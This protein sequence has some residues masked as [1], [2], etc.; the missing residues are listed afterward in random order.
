MAHRDGCAEIAM[1]GRM[2]WNEE[3]IHRV[4]TPWDDRSDDVPTEP[5]VLAGGGGP[6]TE[7]GIA[8]T[9]DV[10]TTGDTRGFGDRRLREHHTD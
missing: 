5:T 9:V 6:S 8:T 3:R 4:H 1:D 10:P 7:A 2:P